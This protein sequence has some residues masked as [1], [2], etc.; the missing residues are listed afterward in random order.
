MG[1]CPSVGE[2]PSPPPSPTQA[3]APPS[4]PP[5]VPATPPPQAPREPRQTEQPSE[6]GDTVER[7]SPKKPHNC[8]AILKDADIPIDRSS[9]EKLLDQL[10]AGVF[11]NKKRKKYWVERTSDHNCFMLFARDLAITW[12]AH[13]LYWRWPSFKE[14]RILIFETVREIHT[15]HLS[16]CSDAF[17]EVAEVHGR[18]E[19]TNLSPGIVYEVL[20]VVMLKEPAYGW[21][22]PVNFRLILPDGS[23]QGHKENLMEKETGKWIEILA[24]KVMAIPDNVGD[25]QFSLY[26][27][28]GGIW[29]RSLLYLVIAK[30]VSPLG[31][32]RESSQII[33]L[34]SNSQQLH[35]LM[36]AETLHPE[37]PYKKKLIHAERRT[38][39]SLG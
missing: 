11:L 16:F 21:E 38:I 37:F 10:Y 36:I 7:K 2:A 4:P 39:T 12:A 29:K 1:L 33:A 24:G 5:Q 28:E 18:F 35:N 13:E 19:T 30:S 17:V 23:T 15:D 20:F 14:T 32:K 34:S 22:V 9:V 6:N 31:Q 3:P 26:E 27:Y 25:I 8:E